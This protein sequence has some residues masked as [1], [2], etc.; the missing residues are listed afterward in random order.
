M[1]LERVGPHT[2]GVVAEGDRRDAVQFRFDGL[3]VL[4][5]HKAGRVAAVH[6]IRYAVMVA[7]DEVEVAHQTTA[8]KQRLLPRGLQS[9]VPKVV[10][11]IA[12]TDDGVVPLYQRLVM[13]FNCVEGSS[14][15]Q[16]QDRALRLMQPLTVLAERPFIL[17]LFVG[18]YRAWGFVKGVVVRGKENVRFVG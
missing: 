1:A 16:G 14:P 18:F 15:A 11:E 10:D 17:P 6:F 9:K 5:P 13:F 4:H 7:P 2:H 12:R 3:Q 8:E